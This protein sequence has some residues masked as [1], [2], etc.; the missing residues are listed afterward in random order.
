MTFHY[1]FSLAS[2]TP[3]KV[4][5]KTK[6]HSKQNP[7]RGGRESYAKSE[8][9][10]TVEM[11]TWSPPGQPL[12]GAACSVQPVEDLYYVQRSAGQSVW[13]QFSLWCGSMWK[14]QRLESLP[15]CCKSVAFLKEFNQ[16][17]TF[18]GSAACQFWMNCAFFQDICS[19]QCCQWLLISLL[20]TSDA[21]LLSTCIYIP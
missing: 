10:H 20:D 17:W 19:W 21:I 11:R 7:T 6:S 15:V 12:A 18:A 4:K 9:V 1:E 8:G 13:Q 16:S 2:W 5:Y 14:G 3:S